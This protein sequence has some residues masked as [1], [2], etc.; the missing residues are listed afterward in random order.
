[1][2]HYLNSSGLWQTTATWA[3][4]ATDSSISGPGL[5]G[6]GQAAN[7]QQ[8]V[9]F[10]D[11]Q[12]SNVIVAPTATQFVISSV[13]ATGQAGVP[14]YITITAQDANSNTVTGYRGT[15]HFTSSD[16]HAVL[17]PDY[18]FTVTDEGTHTFS[19][20][21]NSTGNQRIKATD[22][23]NSTVT[24]VSGFINV[25][26]G[27]TSTIQ[28]VPQKTVVPFQQLVTLT[29]IV[30]DAIGGDNGAYPTETVNF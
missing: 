14:I 2:D 28:N 6:L 25:S 12:A 21:L 27:T 23:Q 3:V 30:S 1:M 24:R 18:T 4:T 9:T 5:V 19:V 13:P 11:F 8:K 26:K 17:P 15:V 7:S 20:I 10:D 22:T 16:A 29:A